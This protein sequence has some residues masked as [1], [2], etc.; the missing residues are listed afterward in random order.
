MQTLFR[1]T[2][3]PRP[4]RAALALGAAWLAIVA[5]APWAQSGGPYTL[6]KVV[7]AGGVGASGGTYSAVL[8][9]AQPVAG[10]SAGASYRLR[11]GIHPLRP[12]GLV[13]NDRV[14]CDGFE[15]TP[16]P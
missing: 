14:F 11:A 13:N 5:S 2:R 10:E 6:R 15:S 12:S 16:C 7:I 3:G 9:A 8:T 4:G 1:N